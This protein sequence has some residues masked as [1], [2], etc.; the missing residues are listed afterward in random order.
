MINSIGRLNY[1]GNVKSV[2][3]G[4]SDYKSIPGLN[5]A[6]D[7]AMEIKEAL[8]ESEQW[9]N[10]EI[11]LLLNSRANKKNITEAINKYAGKLTQKDTFFLF[12]S[13]H[14]TND[15]AHT[16]LCPHDTQGPDTNS[17]ISDEEFKTLIQALAQNPSSPPKVCVIFDSC[18]S[19]GMMEQ[20]KC[21]TGI[22]SKFYKL[23][24]SKENFNG[25]TLPQKTA[26]LKNCTVLTA[27]AKDEVSL[28]LPILKNGI[29][30]YHVIQGLGDG[31]KPGR[32]DINKDGKISAEETHSYTYPRVTR[33]PLY[34]EKQHPQIYD[35]GKEELIIKG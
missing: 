31:K 24:S 2:I 35:G 3:I 11:N 9:R 12:F 16:Y 32:G 19:G 10:A 25:T 7:D 18:F 17:L 20:F 27:S 28:E 6:D 22:K 30:S 21:K 26:A 15:G 13:G 14:G 8:E 33:F 4:I 1:Y 5:Y 34:F 29:F 23:K